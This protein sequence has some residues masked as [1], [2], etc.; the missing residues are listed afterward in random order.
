MKKESQLHPVETKS[1]VSHLKTNTNRHPFSARS[2]LDAEF[3]HLDSQFT[4]AEYCEHRAEYRRRGDQH[5]TYGTT[6][7][8]YF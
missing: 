1:Q 5:P 2:C 8:L 7:P 3:K 6:D 4:Y